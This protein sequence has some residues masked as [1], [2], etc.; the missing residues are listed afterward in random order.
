MKKLNFT[1]I[2]EEMIWLWYYD[3]L[4]NKHLKELLGKEARDFMQDFVSSKKVV[5]KS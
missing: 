2:S 5:K 3:E 1:I 4:G